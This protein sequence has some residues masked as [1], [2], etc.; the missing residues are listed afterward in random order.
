MELLDILFLCTN[1]LKKYKQLMQL[2]TSTAVR[3]HNKNFASQSVY[4]C[5]LHAGT[6]TAV[7]T[8]RTSPPLAAAAGTLASVSADERLIFFV[9]PAKLPA[10]CHARPGMSVGGAAARR[11]L[12]LRA[13]RARRAV[14]RGAVRPR[15]PG[16]LGLGC[17]AAPVVNRR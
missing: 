9:Q 1:D 6:Y 2:M 11:P 16:T 3:N 13:V 12:G 17:P 14:G 10:G 8:Q 4:C 7:P 15:G 5:V